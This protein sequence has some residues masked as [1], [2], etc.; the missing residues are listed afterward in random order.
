MSQF[1]REPANKKGTGK[2]ANRYTGAPIIVDVRDMLCA[3]ALA[4]VAGA[5]KRLQPGQALEIRFNRADV[6]HDL[7]AWVAERGWRLLSHTTDTMTLQR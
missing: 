2:L 7:L 4:L 6:E 3:Q 5:A 1:A